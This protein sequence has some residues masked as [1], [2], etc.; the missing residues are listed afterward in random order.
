MTTQQQNRADLVRA[1][2][3][4]LRDGGPAFPCKMIDFTGGVPG[5]IR[6]APE[7]PHDGMSLRDYFAG[8]AIDAVSDQWNAMTDELRKVHSGC[9]DSGI[10]WGRDY[11][12]FMAKQ[13]YSVADAM[14]AERNR[15]QEPSDES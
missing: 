7:F 13:A 15:K 5:E 2:E 10:I 14:L 1:A 11:Q 3:Q 4:R 9:V 6:V 8:Q 12:R